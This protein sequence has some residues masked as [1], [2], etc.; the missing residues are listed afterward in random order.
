MASKIKTEENPAKRPRLDK[1]I[2][3]N[4][5]ISN[6]NKTATRYL[7]HRIAF[8]ETK[9]MAQIIIRKK[10]HTYAWLK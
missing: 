4:T 8:I 10:P 1:S 9:Y 2:Q 5:E 7:A 6:K 3:S